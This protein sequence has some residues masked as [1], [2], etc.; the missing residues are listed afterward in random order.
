MTSSKRVP[1]TQT[2]TH[3]P[4]QHARDFFLRQIAQRKKGRLLLELQCF[5]H[6]FQHRAALERLLDRAQGVREAQVFR[7]KFFH[8][9]HARF[10]LLDLHDRIGRVKNRL[11]LDVAERQ[12]HGQHQTNGDQPEPLHQ[13]MVKPFDVEAGRR[14]P[15]AAAQEK[16]RPYQKIFS[17]MVIVSSA[18]ISKF[19][20]SLS[21]AIESAS[22]LKTFLSDPSP[23]CTLTPRPVPSRV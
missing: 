22:S 11:A 8:L 16:F 17:P 2:H 20:T 9:H 4:I 1:L 15:R 21:L 6:A 14:R 13:S 12:K 19:F 23:R 7:L 5:R 18:I 10:V 3:H